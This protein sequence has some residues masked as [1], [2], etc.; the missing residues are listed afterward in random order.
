[1]VVFDEMGL[2]RASLGYGDLPAR[3]VPQDALL[4]I[5]PDATLA[6]RVIMVGAAVTA[7]VSAAKLGT[8]NLGKAAAMTVLL[9]NP[10]VVER[11]LQGHWS[12]V[13]AGW[14]LVAAAAHPVAQWVASLTPTGAIAAALFSKNYLVSALT[15][16]PWVVAGLLYSGPTTSSAAGL[17][18]FAPRAETYVGTLGAL[19]GFGG[20][21]NAHA[22][23][24]SRHVGFALFGI[25]LF[26]VLLV[27]WNSAPRTW[28]ALAALGF[29]IPLAAW[30]GITAPI[31]EH[32][33]GGGLLRDAHKWII[34]ALP[35]ATAA[36]GS[37]TPKLAGAALALAILQVPDAPTAISVLAPT[38]IEVPEVDHRGRDVLFEDRALV[39]DPAA[40]AMNVVEHGA[41]VVDGVLVDPPSV[42][43]VNAQTTDPEALG[44]GLVVHPDG[45]VTDTGA[46]RQPWPIPG[47]VTFALWWIAPLCGKRHTVR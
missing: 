7:A 4:G 37:L 1:M 46:P 27:G 38:S 9:W 45:S 16:A 13:A 24:D 18:A 10:F 28:L 39:P 26:P 12:L 15:C 29:A 41:I 40:K 31:V 23:P 43:W 36:A 3:N 44:I 47:V 5:V 25:L 20:I 34:L 19:M 30:A 33:P 35:A 8:T 17:H 2:T 32:V 6:L 21:W 42:R 14:L 22:V 11:L